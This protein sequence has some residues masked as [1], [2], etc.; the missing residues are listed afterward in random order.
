MIDVDLMR[1]L[2]ELVHDHHALIG[3]VFD[4]GDFVDCADHILIQQAIK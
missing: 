4:E 2:V 3:L 1:D